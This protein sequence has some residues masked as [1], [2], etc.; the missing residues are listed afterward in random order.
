MK[1]GGKQNL[2]YRKTANNE[3]RIVFQYIIMGKTINKKCRMIQ[4]FFDQG[5]VK[6]T[7]CLKCIIYKKKLFGANLNTTF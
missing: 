6:R 3:D 4:Y 2:E 1:T 5:F 7:L